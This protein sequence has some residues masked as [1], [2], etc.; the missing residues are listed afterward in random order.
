MHCCSSR[1]A[2]T[3]PPLQAPRQALYNL[4]MIHPLSIALAAALLTP[5]PALADLALAK[6][7]NCMACHAMDKK[8]VGPA[9]THIAQKYQGSA[10]V[11]P[12]LAQR[13]RE[14]SR[15]IWGPVPMP[16]NNQVSPEQALTL[17]TWVLQQKP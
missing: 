3:P 1:L 11:A 13:I 4:S 10:E 6:S 8:V 9:F 12:V 7:K 5:L 2:Q 17:A 15:G 16:A 14:G